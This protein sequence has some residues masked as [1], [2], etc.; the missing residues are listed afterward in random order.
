MCAARLGEDGEGPRR[1]RSD[2]VVTVSPVLLPRRARRGDHSIME[3]ALWLHL[4][5]SAA[6][7]LDPI[8]RQEQH[9]LLLLG[10]EEMVAARLASS[11]ARAP[12]ADALEG[13]ASCEL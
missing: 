12:H 7:L 4:K 2:Q 3:A 13:S 5:L 6:G 10:E 11:A 9:M 8:E 1:W